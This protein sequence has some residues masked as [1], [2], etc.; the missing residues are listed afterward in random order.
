MWPSLLSLGDL[1][2]EQGEKQ[3]RKPRMKDLDLLERA[4]RRWIPGA[5]LVGLCRQLAVSTAAFKSGCGASVSLRKR[6]LR[7]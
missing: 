2:T 4:V 7:Q 6:G 1:C 3:Q 5:A